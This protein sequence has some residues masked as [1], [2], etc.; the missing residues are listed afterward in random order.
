MVPC[1]WESLEKD[2]DWVSCFSVVFLC[3]YS[4]PCLEDTGFLL[5]EHGTWDGSHIITVFV[6]AYDYK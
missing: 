5:C 6:K 4:L 1:V 3:I 2:P